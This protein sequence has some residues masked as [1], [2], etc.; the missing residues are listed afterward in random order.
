LSEYGIDAF[1]DFAD[2]VSRHTVQDNDRAGRI[3]LPEGP[4]DRPSLLQTI[5]DK[6]E[7]PEQVSPEQLAEVVHVIL[8]HGQLML[9]HQKALIEWKDEIE[10]AKQTIPKEDC[11][12]HMLSILADVPDEDYFYFTHSVTSKLSEEALDKGSAE[13]QKA[14]INRTEIMYQALKKIEEL[15]G[16]TESS[17][18][19]LSQSFIDIL[20]SSLETIHQHHTIRGALSLRESAVVKNEADEFVPENY[21]RFVAASKDIRYDLLGSTATLESLDEQ[22]F[23]SGTRLRIQDTRIHPRSQDEVLLGS[24]ADGSSLAMRY[25]SLPVASVYNTTTGVASFKLQ[26]ES[27]DFEEQD[28]VFLQVRVLLVPGDDLKL[29]SG[30]IGCHQTFFSNLKQSRREKQKS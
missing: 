29:T 14:L 21:L 11:I 4:V 26:G 16:S 20:C 1:K 10:R 3:P 27:D 17:V 8:K 25:L 30:S 2:Y 15:G 18:S 19:K 28:V 6:L 7:V 24:I 9:R 12:N 23:N 13:D 5:L 22:V